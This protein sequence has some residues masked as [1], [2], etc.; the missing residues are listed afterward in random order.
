M[1]PFSS[2]DLDLNIAKGLSDI[3]IMLGISDIPTASPHLLKETHAPRF[4]A[5][6]GMVGK[7]GRT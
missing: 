7:V 4:P 3:R 2:E 5:S 1:S 6:G